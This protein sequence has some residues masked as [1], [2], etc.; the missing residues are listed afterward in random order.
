MIF[1]EAR[2][3]VFFLVVFAVHWA[4]RANRQRKAWLLLCSYGFYA[5]WD[6]RFLSLI[7]VSTAVDYTAGLRLLAG[8][9]AKRGWLVLSLLCNLGLLGFFKYY[10]FF[11][12]S[13]A[14]LLE[15]FGFG[16]NDATL[17]IVLPVGISF[18]TF[19]TLS[20]TID[21]YRGRLKATRS[22]L[23]FGLFVAFFPQLVAGPIV[24]AID[25]LPQLSSSR[26]LAELTL[27]PYVTLF[28]IGFFKKACIADNVAVI[29]DP[30]FA[31]PTVWSAGAAW[32]AVSLYTIQIYCDFSGY[33]DMAIACAGLLGYRLALNFNFP[34]L[35]TSVT[36]F[37]R[38]WHISLS[39]WFRDYLYIPMGG[40]RRG[41]ARTATNLATVFLLCGLWHG[42]SWTFIVWGGF[43]GVLLAMERGLLSART[44]RGPWGMQVYVVFAWTM[45]MVVFRS[46]SLGSAWAYFGRLADFQA[47]GV[48]P[49]ENAWWLLV[50]FVAALHLIAHRGWVDRL[51]NGVSDVV[52]A[53]GCGVVIGVLL[54]FVA[55]EYQPFIYFQF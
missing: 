31:D 11:A 47:L 49:A 26:R 46:P 7:L 4:L 32:L 8:G 21:V 33:T 20:Y 41:A 3:F 52:Y 23:D 44:G 36:D 50:P 15:W 18:Y 55:T 37:W 14:E 2:F 40:S 38:R 30:V 34:Y 54:S 53:L 16:A 29:V 45:S 24:R 28:L 5:A 10:N 25:F 39:S 9:S 35:A 43:H 48:R 17:S 22:L 13:A 6:W 19:Q 51:T 42:A 12:D 1:T 27:R